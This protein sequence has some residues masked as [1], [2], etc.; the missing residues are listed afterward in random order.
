MY[1][2]SFVDKDFSKNICYLCDNSG[3][4]LDQLSKRTFMK[5]Y[6]N[7]VWIIQPNINAI[8]SE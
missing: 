7:C 3:E 8:K 2:R 6:C 5:K 1:K 4:L